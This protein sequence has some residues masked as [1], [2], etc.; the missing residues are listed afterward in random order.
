MD[1]GIFNLMSLRDHPRGAA[2]VIDDT[3]QMTLLAEQIGF[4]TA[5]FAEHH[6]SNYAVCPSPLMMAAHLAGR[7]SR[8]RLGAAVVVLPLYD[9]L[10]LV[11]EIALLDQMSAGRAVLG[12]GTGY[13]PYEF[14]RFGRNIDRK[15]ELF[16][17]YWS[18]LEQALTEGRAAFHGAHVEVEETVFALRPVQKPMPPVFTTSVDPRILA[19]LGPRGAT[20]FLGAGWLG[21]AKLFDLAANAADAWGKAGLGQTPMKLAVQQYI[22]VTD[23]RA[24]ALEAAERA[25]YVARMV[26][27]LR[28]KVVRLDGAFLDAP[29]LP[30]EPGLDVFR[31][32]LLIGDPHHVA[33]R[34][35]AEIRRLDPVHYNCFLQFGDMPAERALR[36]L[37]RFGAEVLPL[38]DAALGRAAAA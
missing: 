11:Q 5:W 2:G 21:S 4:S 14:T 25:R 1:F 35:V 13:Q 9:P 18:V 28:G 31:D 29:A 19:R 7:T 30:D 34:I 12:L 3:V 37:E 33:E 36:S 10:R 24:E 23:S 17:E 20:V 6:F 26:A 38:V 15:A 22:H 27:T 8:I 32:N 16:L